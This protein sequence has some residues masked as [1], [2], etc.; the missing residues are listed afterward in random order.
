MGTSQVLL[1]DTDAVTKGR[2]SDSTF[3][4]DVVWYH[5]FGEFGEIHK[6]TRSATIFKHQWVGIFSCVVTEQNTDRIL[7]VLVRKMWTVD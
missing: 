1:T 7:P 6:G 2:C 5:G 4:F 3:Q